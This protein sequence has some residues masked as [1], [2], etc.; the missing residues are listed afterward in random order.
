MEQRNIITQTMTNMYN[1]YN[2]I[3]HI[4]Q[5]IEEKIKNKNLLALGGDANV[6]WENSYAYYKPEAWLMS[7][8]AR[9]YQNESQ[10]NKAVGFCMI[11]LAN[12]I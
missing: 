6:T 10:K 5:V 1:I 11:L 7:W 9:C 8:F 3:G 12:D 2:D 4:I